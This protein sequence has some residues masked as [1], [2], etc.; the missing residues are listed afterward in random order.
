MKYCPNCGYQCDDNNKFC[1]KCAY[2]FQ[3]EILKAQK[4]QTCK[5]EQ[6]PDIPAQNVASQATPDG[7]YIALYAEEARKAREKEIR[8]AEEYERRKSEE[9]RQEEIKRIEKRKAEQ[10]ASKEN[11]SQTSSYDKNQN[12]TMAENN[13]PDKVYCVSLFNDKVSVPPYC[14]C[15][16]K[17]TNTTE[18]IGGSLSSSSFNRK[19][20]REVS[21][22]LPICPECKKHREVISNK[23]WLLDSIAIAMGIILTV[24]LAGTSIFNYTW[25]VPVVMTIATFFTLGFIVKVEPLGK[26][27]STRE[28]SVKMTV[29]SVDSFHVK[30][31]FTSLTYAEMFA[32]VNNSR[33]NKYPARNRPKEA[34]LLPA[35]N[36][37]YANGVIVLCVIVVTMLFAL[38][39]AEI[40]TDSQKNSVTSVKPP[41]PPSSVNTPVV[42]DQPVIE[43]PANGY[44]TNHTGSIGL[45]PLSIKTPAGDDYYFILLR[46]SPK[47]EVAVT[48]YIYAGETVEILVPLGD[49]TMHYAVGKV[50]YGEEYL[51]GP[52]T[53]YTNVDKIFKFY[54]TDDSYV[55]HTIELIM[56]FGGNLNTVPGSSSDFLGIPADIPLSELELPELPSY[57]GSVLVK[58]YTIFS[59]T[60]SSSGIWEFETS[61]NGKSD[62]VLAIYD[63]QGILIAEDDDGGDSFNALIT[64]Q[65]EAK[66]EYIIIALCN[67]MNGDSFMLSVTKK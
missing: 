37:P 1:A 16:M 67:K 39:A 41:A 12:E 64:T 6:C 33:I 18:M 45:A 13:E 19:T 26:E 63:M 62:P 59:F 46:S 47:G 53:V 60:P 40:T 42:F 27:H 20:T 50:W 30:L 48:T 29:M 66:T 7:G 55:G 43:F 2:S 11:A 52:D 57:G 44:Y 65:L 36:N 34:K 61:K 54:E 10:R 4:P 3:S 17:P 56:Q 35:L 8:E 49:Y 38:F 22:H 21:L 58:E 24:V 5:I 28:R 31:F 32:Y 14:T 9:A 51:F 23:K 25:F 15:C